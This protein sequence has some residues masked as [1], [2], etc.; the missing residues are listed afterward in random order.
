[1]RTPPNPAVSPTRPPKPAGKPSVNAPVPQPMAAVVYSAMAFV[2]ML[3]GIGLLIYF[4]RQVPHLDPG[5]R[6]QVYYIVL[7]IAGIFCAAAI[8]GA[9]ASFAKLTAR[10]PGW[11]LEL[12]GPAVIFA[13]VVYGGFKL[14]PAAPES[15]D[16]TIRAHAADGS[17]PRIT[18][19]ALL[20]EIGRETR[21]ASFDA[22]GDADFKAIPSRFLKGE[23]VTILP[24]VDGFQTTAISLKSID[25]ATLEIALDRPAEV[26]F[27]GYVQDEGGLPIA[28]VTVT[29]PDCDQNGTTNENGVFVF[30][31][32]PAAKHCRFLFRKPGFAPYTTDEAI[33]NDP[34][35]PFLLHKGR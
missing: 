14:V 34:N 26:S 31:L 11:A 21:T 32:Q 16:L 15:F 4:V 29:S 30:K 10:R 24:H 33:D 9:M 8:S 28:G 20:L 35:H 18:S 25:S 19:G 27:R 5:T 13:L 12:G 3:L 22:N 17:I 1:M 2:A 23:P 6:N 7:L